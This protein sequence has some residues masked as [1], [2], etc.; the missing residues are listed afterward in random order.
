MARKTIYW[1]LILPIWLLTACSGNIAS[2]AQPVIVNE[3]TVAKATVTQT[4]AG[5]EVGQEERPTPRGGL[6]ATDP[7]Q[8]N[9][10]A[11]KVQLVEFF[12]FW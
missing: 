9:L 5:E 4:S 12:A 10:A 3:T 7:S 11:G 8:V 6:E 2:T 1:M